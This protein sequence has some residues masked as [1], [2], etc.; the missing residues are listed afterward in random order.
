M[1]QRGIF[2]MKTPRKQ[3]I[4]KINCKK[5]SQSFSFWFFDKQVYE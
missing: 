3:L 4:K 5:F 2:E 1:N